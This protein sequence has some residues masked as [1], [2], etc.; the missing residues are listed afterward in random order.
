VAIDVFAEKYGA[1]HDKAVECLTKDR[2]TM[3]AFYDFPAEHWD[4]LR[5]TNPIES[6]R[7]VFFSFGVHMVILL[8]LHKLRSNRALHS[9]RQQAIRSDGRWIF[10]HVKPMC[11]LIA[12]GKQSGSSRHDNSE[13]VSPDPFD[14][15]KTFRV[16]TV[17]VLQDVLN[18]N[19]SGSA[20]FTG[21]SINACGCGLLAFQ[22]LRHLLVRVLIILRDFFKI[23]KDFGRITVV[24]NVGDFRGIDLETAFARLR[25]FNLELVVPGLRLEFL[26]RSARPGGQLQIW[27]PV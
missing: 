13:G 15:S 27:R 21:R 19:N 10:Y 23:S 18:G 4:H 5:T 12:Q 3:L 9:P 6:G 26:E 25:R 17:C 20:S 16:L 24:Y 11:F 2:E 22:T 14:A 1:K 8:L 7:R